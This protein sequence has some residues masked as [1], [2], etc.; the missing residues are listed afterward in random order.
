MSQGQGSVG[1]RTLVSIII[2]AYNAQATLEETVKSALSSTHDAIEVIV[3]DDGSSDRTR[4]IAE[5]LA[6]LDHR[7]RLVKR[8]NGGPYAAFRSGLAVARGEWIARLDADDLWHPTKLARQLE[9]ARANPRA[10]FIYTFYRYLDARGRVLFDG[11]PQRFPSRALCRSA[12]ETI[13]GCGSSALIKR[14]AAEEVGDCGKELRNCEDLFLQV[15]IAA[16][17]RIAFVPAYLTGYR[18][19]PAS[20]SQD[21]HALAAG[22][23]RLRRDLR[24]SFPQIPARVS[25]WGH[26]KQ[27]MSLAEGFARRRQF[28]AALRTFMRALQCDPQWASLYL[29]RRLGRLVLRPP[30]PRRP[31]EPGLPFLEYDPAKAHDSETGIYGTQGRFLQRIHQRRVRLL[32]A[33]DDVQPGES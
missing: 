22:S 10:A 13:I 19:C 14:S 32:Q 24:R 17:H 29:M 18:L 16:H 21:L 25:D 28:G 6:A 31:S 23:E 5:T 26:A 33:L 8:A 4:E 30:R 15:S 3:V 7:V 9:V 2:P 11:P 12:Y 27:C 1:E 20:L